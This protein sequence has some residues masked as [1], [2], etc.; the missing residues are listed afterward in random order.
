MI[1]RMASMRLLS[2][3]I[4]ISYML[5]GIHMALKVLQPS[6]FCLLPNVVEAAVTNPVL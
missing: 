4:E 1:I 3:H 6:P 2:L 5:Q